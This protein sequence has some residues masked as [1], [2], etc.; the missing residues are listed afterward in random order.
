MKVTLTV[1]NSDGQLSHIE[2]EGP[3][4]EEAKA[5][6]KAQIEYATLL[7]PRRSLSGMGKLSVAVAIRV[8]MTSGAV[9]LLGAG[10][11]SPGQPAASLPSV[12]SPTAEVQPDFVLCQG[13]EVPLEAL[14]H[15]RLASEL[16]AEAA[17]ALQGR[18]VSAF[19]PVTWLIAQESSDRVMLMNK[20]AAPQDH[21]NGDVRDYMYIVISTQSM[22]SE[23]GKPIWDVVESSTCT[24]TLDL[25][26]LTAGAVTLDPASPPVPES[27][28]LALLVTEFDCNSGQNAE[29]RVEVVKLTETESAVEIVLG[30]R[31]SGKQ[32]AS[33]QGNPATPFTVDLQRPLGTRTVMN[34]AVLPAR[35][36]T[37]P[38]SPPAVAK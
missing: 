12:A 10:C 24:P 16:G 31:P 38:E 6:A 36:I 9:M 19:D 15:P 13:N 23:P 32:T 11:A 22:A 8:S 37:A 21:G 20:L 34:A 7:D 1:E 33:C 14:K 29:G 17:P 5:Q 4:Y 27:D 2:A 30:V 3:T 18:G 25:G 26:Q 35:E 28:R